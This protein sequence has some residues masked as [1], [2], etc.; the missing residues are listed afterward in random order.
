MSRIRRL[1]HAISNNGASL[2]TKNQALTL[3]ASVLSVLE[4]VNN[5]STSRKVTKKAAFTVI[6]RSLY[7]TKG[8][9]FS[10]RQHMALKEL[11]LYINLAQHNKDTSLTLSNTDLLPVS[12]PRSTRNHAMSSSALRISQSRWYADDPRITNEKVK[13]VLASAFASLPG[14]TEHTYFTSLLTSLPQGS[15]P[16]EA[17]L[18]A[19]GGGNSHLA[20]KLRAMKQ[21]RDSKGQFAFEGGGLHIFVR[22]RD[23]KIF[24]LAGRQVAEVGGGDDVQIELPGGKIAEVPASKGTFVKAVLPTPA[25]YTPNPIEPDIEDLPNVINEQDIKYVDA[26]AGWEEN[27]NFTHMLGYPVWQDGAFTVKIQT[28]R[29]GQRHFTLVASNGAGGHRAQRPIGQYKSWA[30][31]QDALRGNEEKLAGPNAHEVNPVQP[32]RPLQEN[33]LER[34]KVQ[35]QQD[36]VDV[37]NRRADIQKF[38]ANGTDEKGNKLPV[39]WHGVE[40]AAT[41]FDRDHPGLYKLEFENNN[42]IARPAFPGGPIDVIDRS[43]LLPKKVYLD[44]DGLK[45]DHPAVQA[46]YTKAARAH[47][48]S[49]MGQYHFPQEDID[50]IDTLSQ[51]EITDL[52]D[53]NKNKDHMPDAFKAALDDYFNRNAVDLPRP[54]QKAKWDSFGKEL[55]IAQHAGDLPNNEEA[56]LPEENAPTPEPTPTPVPNKDV[57]FEFNYPEG[58]YKIQSGETYDPQG[59]IDEKSP[60]FTDDPA[61]LAQK[62]DTNE[63]IGALE[64]AVVPSEGEANASGS[65]ALS[66]KA[67]DEMVDG[68]AIYNA[69]NEQGEDGDMELAKIYDKATGDDNNV[70][71]LNDFRKGPE[72]IANAKEKPVADLEDAFKK[73]TSESQPAEVEVTSKELKEESD[74]SA[75]LPP[76]LEGL[77]TSE[78]LRYKDTQD[79]TEFLPKNND[80]QMPEG[81]YQMDPAP[82]EGWVVIEEGDQ[83]EGL[84]VGATNNPV[85]LAQ[86]LSKKDLSDLLEEAI[87]GK[88]DGGSPLGYAPLGFE[89][90]NGEQVDV[91]IPAEVYRDALQLQGV[92]T[93]AILKDIA[94]KNQA[95]A[96]EAELPAEGAPQASAPS[97]D[98]MLKEENDLTDEFL[99]E[100]LD[101]GDAQSAAES[102]MK[103]KYGKTSQEALAELPHKDAMEALKRN[104]A[105][106]NAKE[107]SPA[108]PSTPSEPTPTPSAPTPEAIPEPVPEQTPEDIAFDVM[109][110]FQDVADEN[111]IPDGLDDGPAPDNIPPAGADG[112]YRISVKVSDM[113]PGDTTA[114]DHFVI[115]SI[116][117]PI[118]GTDRLQIIGHYPGHVSQDT[119]QWNHYKKID[120]IRG[121][122]PPA[123]GDLPVLSKP[124]PQDFG[125]QKR[126]PNGVWGFADPADQD[127]F[128]A[129]MADYNVK[130]D[131][132]KKRFVDPTDNANAPH[133]IAAPAVDLKAGDITADAKR[134]HFVIERT[135]NDADTKVGFISVEGYYAGHVTQ[136]KEWRL[137]TKITVF[138]N[139]EPPKKGDLPEL[140]QPAIVTPDGKWRPDKDP[141]KRA[142][143]Q[144]EIADLQSQWTAPDGLPTLEDAGQDPAGA[145]IPAPNVITAKKPAPPRIPTMPPFQGEVVSLLR[146]AEG[147]WGKFRKLVAGHD[148]IFF[149]FETTGIDETDGNEPWQVGAVRVRDGKIIDRKNIYMHPGRSIAGTYSA[150]SNGKGVPNA[151]D[152]DGK[153]LSDEFLAKQPSQAD[154]M[155]EFFDWVGPDAWLAA[156]NTAFDD[157][158]ARRMAHEHGLNYSPAALIDTFSLAKGIYKDIP[159][160]NRP[161]NPDNGRDSYS[162]GNLAT[163]L[164]LKLDNW[165]AADSDAEATA[166]LFG[167]LLDVAETNKAG[168]DV[169][170]ADAALNDY[171]KAHEQFNIAQGV[172]HEGVVHFATVKAMQD[173]YAGKAVNLDDVV[174]NAEGAV[175]YDPEGI[176][177]G[178]V[179]EEPQPSAP[180]DDFAVLDFTP[181]A[182]YPKGKM[183]LMKREWILDENNTFLM[184]R[185]NARMENIFPGDF[186]SSK[187]GDIIWQVVA[188][189]GGEEFGLAPG[190]IKIYRRDID[191]GELKTYEHWHGT[192][193]DGVRRAKDP[194]DLNLPDNDTQEF[195]ANAPEPQLTPENIGDAPII[196]NYA[197]GENHS[198]RY[199]ISKNANGK[200]DMEAAVF[201]KDGNQIYNVGGS[202]H[203]PEGAKAEAEALIKQHV[204]GLDGQAQQEQATPDA[205]KVADVPI[206]RGDL[207]DGHKGASNQIEVQGLPDDQVG[208]IEIK[209]VGEDAPVFQADIGLFDRE[210]DVIAE[211]IEHGPNAAGVEAEARDFIARASEAHVNPPA[212]TPEQEAVVAEEAKPASAKAKRAKS[213]PKPK[214][215]TQGDKDVI[216]NNNWVEDHAGRLAPLEA[217]DV[218]VGDFFWNAFHKRYEEVQSVRRIGFLNR[219]EFQVFN[220]KN[221]KMET[222][223]FEENSPLRNMRRPGIKDQAP[224][225]P[226][227]VAAPR[228][229]ARHDILREPENVRIIAKAGRAMG[230]NFDKEGYYKDMNGDPIAPGDLVVHNN[231]NKAKY[232]VGRVLRRIGAQ[233]NEGKKV[234]GLARGGKVYL[235]YVEVQFP[236]GSIR[237]FKAGKL[238]KQDAPDNAAPNVGKTVAPTK[239]VPEVPTPTPTGLLPNPPKPPAKPEVQSFTFDATNSADVKS[240]I[241]QLKDAV[242]NEGVDKGRDRDRNNAISALDDFVSGLNVKKH[243]KIKLND[244]DAAI[245][246][247]NRVKDANDAPQAEQAAKDLSVLRDN[248]SIHKDALEKVANQAMFD[249]LKEPLVEPVPTPESMTFTSLA[250]ALEEVANK[251]PN[252]QPDNANKDASNLYKAHQA[253]QNEL[254]SLESP[255]DILDNDFNG[256]QNAID[257]LGRIGGG[258]SDLQDRLSEIAKNIK[259]Y[260]KRNQRAFGKINMPEIDPV[261]LTQK[262]IADKENP[263]DVGAA[264]HLKSDFEDDQLFISHPFLA[265]YKDELRAFFAHPGEVP[266]ASLSSDARQALA[267]YVS[268][269]LKSP[270]HANMKPADKVAWAREL[271]GVA[272]ALHDERLAFNPNRSSFGAIGDR[273]KGFDTDAVFDAARNIK[274]GKGSLLLNGQDTG[275]RVER[276]GAGINSQQNVRL[277]HKATGQVFYLKRERTKTEA[278]AEFASNQLGR[279]LGISGIP[280]VEKSNTDPLALIMSNAGDSLDW[281]RDPRVANREADNPDNLAD[282]GAI[283]DLVSMGVLDAVINNTDRH[284]GNFLIGDVDRGNVKANGDEELQLLPIDQGFAKAFAGGGMRDPLA[285]MS[286][287]DGRAGGEVNKA[288]AKA[289]GATTYK[290]L[291]DN[292]VLRAT[293]AIDSGEFMSQITPVQKTIV[294][295]RLA[296]LAGVSVAEWKTKLAKKA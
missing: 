39:G 221:N 109:P 189:R 210:G 184:D 136:R 197:V 35:H 30:E 113:Q 118:P 79:H 52:F 243:E 246:R 145:P 193:L 92:D 66:F 166:E 177:L 255:E 199:A 104:E 28:D 256:I 148:V 37:T 67:G 196:A 99:Q 191:N 293:R 183:R 262:R 50:S 277:I 128:D 107:Q 220:V 253:I 13:T 4:S 263:I 244:L 34:R 173:A 206:S 192:R 211:G 155:K 16:T 237:K 141:A 170:N 174:G 172:Y 138:R 42:F 116:G 151:I 69:L 9:P 201:D 14:S 150:G 96:P 234:G 71:A 108:S 76:L 215:L 48:K 70:N 160:E 198:A 124:K 126:L 261:A 278:N 281:V 40:Y 83:V 214:E 144:K 6:L 241:A 91:N 123:T 115:E 186:M 7:K 284:S 64:E 114:G 5:T 94:D 228:G 80:I 209:Q 56:H 49:L 111:A 159:S 129:A 202:Y 249:K 157:E 162:L 295:G 85:H 3:R 86:F 161:K 165:H 18:A 82:F 133:K 122:T 205:K 265:P 101:P 125:K 250:S 19:F 207:P 279:A 153:P 175:N 100:G 77:S 25:G 103:K 45:K 230:G 273:I 245:R 23:G 164:G 251:L 81:L 134:G 149:D 247:L 17:L 22:M 97:I 266:T 231:A 225:I 26:P 73:V 216:K 178:I 283:V 1:G 117:A 229:G 93:N 275:F 169:F 78:K 212:L 235:D 88:T 252:V 106:I 180:K 267:Q 53:E 288:L 57:N 46:E 270:V 24:G 257:Y 217:V 188:V 147:D 190:R 272:E 179:G 290:E 238:V 98:D 36:K 289:V 185:N 264:S 33:E 87:T 105:R 260:K 223:F 130:L 168:L 259:E 74:N 233:V 112:P 156:H 200:Y 146:E 203:T 287:G 291:V 10:L 47:I 296:T 163:H 140:H 226:D 158:I 167:K 31:V 38:I 12:H 213:E 61:E 282:K 131:E 95:P 171:K 65:G 286:G 11:S 219:V 102:A 187:D 121:I 44:L 194:N 239:V 236:D 20:R 181:N 110:P 32:P 119:K 227:N 68:K 232:G 269:E 204:M 154:G 60:D 285:Y 242:Q 15:I 139:V 135:F 142:A 294:L 75:P 55:Y 2:Q 29:N 274:N 176:N 89:D 62:F 254:G 72:H 137:D 276:V 152:G 27:K 63:L 182:Q 280:L 208:N 84:P 268:G 120:V 224:N 127:K 222:R 51:S 258:V 143:F 58:A 21:R 54:A 218:Q 195:V 240:K 8:L 90:E 292:A 271:V 248:L 43:G 59:R 132:A 41:A